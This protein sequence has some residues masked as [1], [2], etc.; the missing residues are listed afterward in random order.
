M[1]KRGRKGFLEKF[2]TW[3]GG[4]IDGEGYI[5][6]QRV[7]SRKKGNVQYELVAGVGNIEAELV[8]PFLRFGGSIHVRKLPAN[9]AHSQTRYW[10]IEARQALAFLEIIEPY[11][12]SP[13]KRTAAKLGVEFQKQKRYGTSFNE[14]YKDRQY[15]FYLQMKE[16]THRGRR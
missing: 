10:K 2:L 15:Q 5:G 7:S 9:P 6:I 12:R 11:L 13:K 1:N 3:A 16:I 8:E 4:I 14:D